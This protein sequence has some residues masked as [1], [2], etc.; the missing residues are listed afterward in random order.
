MFTFV[1]MQVCAGN[2][3]EKERHLIE[4]SENKIVAQSGPFKNQAGPGM[5][6][7]SLQKWFGLSCLTFLQYAYL[8][9]ARLKHS[10]SNTI[11]ETPDIL[12]W[13]ALLYWDL[14]NSGDSELTK[15]TLKLS[16]AERVHLTNVFIG[17]FSWPLKLEM[18]LNLFWTVPET[19]KIII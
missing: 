14:H 1:F 5:L 8:L 9:N 7:S 11:F 17:I 2:E 13:N 3:G 19:T 6:Q 16:L 15:Q 12:F 4:H 18:Q 10:M